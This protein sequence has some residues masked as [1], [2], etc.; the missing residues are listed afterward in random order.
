MAVEVDQVGDIRRIILSGRLDAEGVTEV[1]TEFHEAA[2]AEPNVIVDLTAV[3]FL[4][5]LGI[6][7]LVSASQDQQ[8]VG[9]K[10]VLVS[11]DETTLRILKTTGIH[12]LIPVTESVDEAVS[13]F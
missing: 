5:S 6:R 1:E 9:G 10:V 8:K 4:A 11:P 3:P 12:H 7:M 2:T 13:Q